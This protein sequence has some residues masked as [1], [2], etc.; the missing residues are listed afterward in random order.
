MEES[1]V[2]AFFLQLVQKYFQYLYGLEKRTRQKTEPKRKQLKIIQV[3]R[4]SVYL[5]AGGVAA[6]L[7]PVLVRRR[8]AGRTAPVLPTPAVRYSLD[9]VLL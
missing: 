3:S 7:G 6:L 9:S 4:R 5:V 2:F 1:P 8:R